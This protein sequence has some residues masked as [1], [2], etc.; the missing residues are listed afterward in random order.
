MTSSQ[1]IGCEPPLCWTLKGR[2]L[3]SS[4]LSCYVGWNADMMGTVLGLTG[5]T[6][7]SDGRRIRRSLGLAT[8]KPLYHP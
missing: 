4:S 2:H 6:E 7:P 5:G 1:P 8:M 3:H